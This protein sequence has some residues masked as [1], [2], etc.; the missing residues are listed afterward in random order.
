MMFTKD[1][2]FYK[3][4]FSIFGILVLQNVIVLS[5]NL[6][7]N[8]MLGAYNE[9]ALSGVAAVNQ[10]QFILQQLMQGCGDSLVVLGSQYWG[11]KRT[12][13][14]KKLSAIAMRAALIF[15]CI[16]FVIVSLFPHGVLSL[17]TDNE[18]IIAE[19]MGYLNIIRFSYLI[20]AVTTILL[21]TLRSVETVRIAFF[22]SLSTLVINCAI[23]YTL[24]YGN[25]GFPQLGA[26]GAAI[27]TLIARIIELII[28]ITY[29]I[30]KDK[31]LRLKLK[32]YFH[33]DKTLLHDYIHVCYPVIIVAGLWGFSTALQTVILGHLQ[34]NAIAANSIASTLF[35]I[36]K[37]ASS[38]ASS[39]ATIITGKTIGSGNMQKVREYTKTLQWMFLCIG[40]LTSLLLF[41]VK[42]PVLSLYAL[43]DETKYLANA[44]LCVLC[45]TCIGTAYQM[46]VLTGIIRGGGDTRFTMI[47]D[48]ISIWGIV[49]PL[50][51]LGAFYFRWPPVIVV[52]CLNSDQIFKCAAAFI[53]VNSYKWMKKLT[54]S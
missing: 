17:F 5:V 47:N 25:F 10:I 3:N 30:R 41:L 27:G 16:L 39:C 33:I 48:I 18:P 53:R 15:A 26:E 1:K 7:D 31:Y 45:V 8:L 50:S 11:Q 12:D 52:C 32:D 4:F 9:T 21:A 54:R 43:T 14:V 2:A 37:V 6:A 38:G 19:G 13:P 29:L 40:I 35:L 34:A 42:G 51:F 49:L 20:F 36:F 23:N 22:V 44:F 24:I 46:P 28:V